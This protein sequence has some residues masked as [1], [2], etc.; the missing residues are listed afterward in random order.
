MTKYEEI[1]SLVL[2]IADLQKAGYLII[3]NDGDLVIGDWEE[4]ESLGA[5]RQLQ[6]TQ[7]NGYKA[8][9]CQED[10]SLEELQDGLNFITSCK[11][12]KA[13]DCL[14]ILDCLNEVGFADYL[15]GLVKTKFEE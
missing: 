11:V 4:G 5:V 14:P 1:R 8:V 15:E 9:I 2:R 7:S 13:E 10:D 12:I 6:I 3:D